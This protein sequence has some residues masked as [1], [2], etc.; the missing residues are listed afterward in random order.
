[1][2]DGGHH[3]GQG[4]IGRGGIMHMVGGGDIQ[5]QVPCQLGQ[6]GDALIIIGA[7]MVMQFD[8]EMLALE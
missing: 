8:E 7:A 1:M 4:F 2:A 3:I 5:A 6:G